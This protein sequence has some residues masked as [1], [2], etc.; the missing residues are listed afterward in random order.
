MY[1]AVTESQNMLRKQNNFSFIRIMA[2]LMVLFSH[3]YP[4]SGST[5]EPLSV[6]GLSF[7]HV[8]VD[9][10]FVISGYLVTKSVITRDDIYHF[11]GVRP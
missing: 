10:F 3:S 7:G 6:V 9:I 8:G 5:G 4:L 2:A 11:F 1:A